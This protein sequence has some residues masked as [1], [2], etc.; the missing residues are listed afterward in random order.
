MRNA[1]ALIGV[2]HQKIG[3]WLREGE[4]GG[5]SHIPDDPATTA[6]ID[7]AFEIHKDLAREQAKRDGVPFNAKAPVYVERKYLHKR[8]EKTGEPILGDR[9]ISGNTEF[10]RQELRDEWI[11][12]AVKSKRFYKV[13]VRS[14]VNLQAYFGDRAIEEIKS[15]RKRNTTPKRLA[16]IM[17]KSFMEREKSEKGRIVNAQIPFSFFTQSENTMPGAEPWRVVAGVE[18]KLAQKHSPAATGPGTRF[19]YEYLLQLIPA[20]Y[21]PAPAR[22][23]KP[24]RKKPAR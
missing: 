4:Q 18:E 2:S 9:V 5:V 3:R 6:A 15:G 10:I 24:A 16:N 17:L 21:V 22:T 19:A 8:D 13:N 11:A 23:R 14:R 7:L 1:G 20:N 12:G